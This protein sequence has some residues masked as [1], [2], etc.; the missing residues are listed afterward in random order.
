MLGKKCYEYLST[1]NGLLVD[2]YSH[3][4][5]DICDY[6]KLEKVIRNYN[7][8]INCAAYTNVDKAQQEEQLCMRINAS[9]VLH[10]AYFCANYNVKLIHISSDFIYGNMNDDTMQP[11][12]Q[13][14]PNP[15][16]VYGK[17]KLL[18]QKNIQ[19]WLDNSALILRVSWTFGEYG[20]NFIRKIYEKL[21]DPTCTQLTVVDDQIGRPTSTS[22]IAY[23][24]AH[25]IVGSGFLPGIYNLSNTGD[26]CS[27]YELAQFINKEYNFN[28]NIIPIKTPISKNCA[29]RQKN[30]IFNLNNLITYFYDIK[31]WKYMVKQ[32]L[33][34]YI[35]NNC[36]I[37]NF[38]AGEKHVNLNSF[39]NRLR[40]FFGL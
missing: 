16:S 1:I 37:K 13:G 24:I 19:K 14:T 32:Y 15:I 26:V 2:I 5:L 6:N 38:K 31:D 8:V 4:Q 12:F 23:V 33:D 21:S 7:Y 11:L 40:E 3:N 30:S 18:G 36:Q 9:A 25:Y 29:K 17:S 27:K 10:L 35:N 39:K 22:T 34:N 28:K 20:N